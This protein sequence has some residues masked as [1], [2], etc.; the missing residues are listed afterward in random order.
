MKNKKFLFDWVGQREVPGVGG[1][2]L[3]FHQA[4][5]MADFGNI[6]RKQNERYANVSA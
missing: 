6:E 5:H 4:G 2:G 1:G 3:S